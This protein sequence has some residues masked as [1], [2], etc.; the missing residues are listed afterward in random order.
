MRSLH[1]VV[2]FASFGLMSG[3]NATPNAR[4]LINGIAVPGALSAEECDKVVEIGKRLRVREG[5]LMG[6]DPTG[7]GGSPEASI[8]N[9][10]VAFIRHDADTDWIY[11][12]V[13]GIVDGVNR[14]YW[15]FGLTGCEPMQFATYGHA[16]FYD[17]HI[18]LGDAEPYNKRKLSVSV[19]MSDPADYDGGEL[20]T[21]VTGGTFS[22]AKE[23]GSLIVFPSYLVHRVT[24]IT[25]GERYS[26]V[27][28]IVGEM[29]FH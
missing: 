26:L 29:P 18:D 17:W 3:K 23:R 12:K 11:Q 14:Q 16:E 5:T 27:A 25:R 7:V 9:N 24:P 8:R 13:F 28:W 15:G 4:K 10:R 22:Q 2:T 1:R 19:Q 6:S 21:R 20:E